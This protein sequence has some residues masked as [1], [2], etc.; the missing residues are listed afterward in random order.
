[1]TIDAKGQITYGGTNYVRVK[2]RQ[3]D[4]VPLSSVVTLLQTADRIGFFELRDQYR[5]IRKPDGTEIVTFDRPTTFVTITRGGQTKRVEDYFGTPSGLKKLEQ[6]IDETARTKRWIRVDEPMLE[7]MLRQGQS[8][9]VEERAQLLA[10]A[11]TYDEVGVV[12]RL[13]EMGADPSATYSETNTSPLMLVQSAA[14]ARALLAAGANPFARSDV[15]WTPLGQAAT[16]PPDVTDMLLKAGV[17]VDEP[18]DSDGQTALWQAACRGNAEVVARLLAAGADPARR[19]GRVSPLECARERQ[20]A[21]R[22]LREW[23]PDDK[24]RFLED[25]DGVIGLLVQALAK[26]RR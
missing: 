24:P 18:T 21:V 22:R 3:T 13:L 8:P 19:T 14:A 26:R 7:Q 25:F 6:A 11:L 17:R 23:L 16:L 2:G 1:V 9:T 10:N 12:R 5:T 15:G 4:T 20:A